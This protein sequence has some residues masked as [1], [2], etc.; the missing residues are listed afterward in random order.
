MSNTVALSS[1]LPADED[2][3]GVDALAE[4]LIKDPETFRVAVVTF[5]VDKI[6]NKISAGT[7]VPTI[8]IRRFEPI[9]T[10]DE[11]PSEIQKLIDQRIETRTGR[12]PLPLDAVEPVLPDG[13]SE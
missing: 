10:V 12:K 1:K 7:E 2:F 11:I 9:G 6:T 3:N 13:D 8:L 5:E 4:I